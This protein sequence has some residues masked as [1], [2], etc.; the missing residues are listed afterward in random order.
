M[1]SAESGLER[2]RVAVDG[3]RNF[4]CSRCPFPLVPA[5]VTEL[6][7]ELKTMTEWPKPGARRDV[8]STAAPFSPGASLLQPG[9]VVVG[10][11]LQPPISKSRRKAERRRRAKGQPAAGDVSPAPSASSLPTIASPATVVED[12]ASLAVTKDDAPTPPC[13][14]E[15]LDAD[16]LLHLF[17]ILNTTDLLS[18]AAAYPFAAELV[19]SVNIVAAREIRCFVTKKTARQT[20]LGI[21]LRWNSQLKGLE[22]SFD[23]LSHEAWTDLEIRMGLRRERFTH[24]LP[25]AIH[26]SHFSRARKEII[27]RLKEIERKLVLGPGKGG[28]GKREPSI[29]GYRAL[30]SFANEI[31]VRLMKTADEVLAEPEESFT[32]WGDWSTADNWW[33]GCGNPNCP[34]CSNRPQSAPTPKP[35]PKFVSQSPVGTLLH[36]SEKALCDFVSVIHLAASLA[37]ANPAIA[38]DAARS[39]HRF[40]R[41]PDGRRKEQTPDLGELLIQLVLCSD[42]GWTDLRG[43]L[44]Q[45]SFARQVVWMLDPLQGKGHTAL[46]LLESE[47]VSEWRLKTSFEASRTSL[48]LVMFQHAFLSQL[49][50]LCGKRLG[51]RSTLLE[52]KEGLDARYGLPP[53]DMPGRLVQQIKDIYAVRLSRGVALTSKLTFA[54]VVGR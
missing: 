42:V 36:A 27:P 40:I 19:T 14:L 35:K 13:H 53:R 30:C 43:P 44:L 3:L 4:R 47:S 8:A 18:L 39:V 21:G 54:Y 29:D 7:N 24:W 32:S 49:P 17:N 12:I 25:M 16:V 26:D 48:R 28:A 34:T 11:G 33:P 23:W 1:L 50:A 5:A 45:E 22:S 20:L 38:N 15:R 51:E 31:V 52:L 6:K 2:R 9:R 10:A 46:A 37:V 41:Y